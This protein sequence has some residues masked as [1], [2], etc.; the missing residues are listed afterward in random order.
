[1]DNA[2]HLDPDRPH[3]TEHPVPGDASRVIVMKD[4]KILSDARQT[5]KPAVVPS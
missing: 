3:A 4:G 2:R 1:M 5:P